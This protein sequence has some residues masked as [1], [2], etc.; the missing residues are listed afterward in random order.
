MVFFFLHTISVKCGLCLSNAVTVD[1]SSNISPLVGILTFA[2]CSLE[3][4]PERLELDFMNQ[5]ATLAIMNETKVISF[6]G[7]Q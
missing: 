7:G 2:P 1:M 6:T 3:Q 5:K 4:N